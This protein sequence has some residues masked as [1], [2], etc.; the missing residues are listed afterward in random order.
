MLRPEYIEVEDNVNLHV[1]DYGEGPT[2]IFIHGWPLSNAM[3]EYQYSALARQG[4]RVVGISLRGYGLS[5]KPYGDYSYDR[6]ADDLKA[7]FEQID[8][9]ENAVL[10]GFSM[11]GAIA[12]HYAVKYQGQHISRLALA[13]AALPV[14][15]RR[16]GFEAG[17]GLREANEFI[18]LNN[19]NR[20]ELFKEFGKIFA[21]SENALPAG[22]TEWLSEIQMQ[23]SGYATEQG[24]IALRDTDLRE[25]VE[26]VSM[27]VLIL[28]GKKD[29]ICPFAFAEYMHEHM[30]DSE[31]VPFEHSGHALFY[32][33]LEKFNESL[34][35]FAKSEIQQVIT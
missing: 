29:K 10:C 20:P 30:P 17:H 19:T 33:E 22:I 13:G 26:M 32:E 4:L 16:D 6:H 27:P 3:F 14:W 24:L 28:H 7:V 25:A 1:V 31:L 18:E 11:G 2:V 8:I 21:A 9:V 5:D 12:L 35:R 15:T 23:S 34:V